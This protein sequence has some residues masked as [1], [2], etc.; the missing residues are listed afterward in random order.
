[1][2]NNTISALDEQFY[3]ECEVIETKYEYPQFTGTEKWIIITDLTEEELNIKYTEQIAPLKPFIIAP[4]SF[5]EVRDDYRRNE[6]KHQMRAIRSGH[7]FDFSE[8]T[9]EH[10]T[11]II[12]SVSLEDEMIYNEEMQR[13]REAIQK[14]NTLQKTRLVKYFFDS[15]TLREIASEENVCVRAVAKSVEVAIKNLKN[16][17]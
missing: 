11:E 5:G 14:L 3:I 15:K 9:E 2:N 1:M 17:L 6:K 13:L 7:A 8:D 4:R 10:H 16:F 12:S